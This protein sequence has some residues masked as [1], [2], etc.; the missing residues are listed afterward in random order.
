MHSQIWESSQISSESISPQ[1]TNALFCMRFAFL[2]KS[3]PVE[4]W[5]QDDS[6]RWDVPVTLTRNLANSRSTFWGPPPRQSKMPNTVS[7]SSGSLCMADSIRYA[8]SVWLASGSPLPSAIG[9]GLQ[10]SVNA[11]QVWA[12]AQINS[13]LQLDP[14]VICFVDHA[15]DLINIQ[16]NLI[17]L[18]CLAHLHD[19]I[20][21]SA[22]FTPYLLCRN[23]GTIQSWLP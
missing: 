13:L 17:H 18:V 3:F 19:M 21:A 9:K 11:L 14:G 2:L 20:Q 7:Q 23:L 16:S 10:P 22:C 12:N 15:D 4:W 6:L 8:H 1:Q 5:N